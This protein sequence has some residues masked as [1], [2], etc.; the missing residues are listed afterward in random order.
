MPSLFSFSTTT[1]SVP[2]T[3]TPTPNTGI[4][5]P[6]T[7]ASVFANIFQYP[8]TTSTATSQS[9]VMR[10]LTSEASKAAIPLS[11]RKTTLFVSKH[12]EHSGERSSLRSRRSLSDSDL[13]APSS[14]ADHQKHEPLDVQHVDSAT[15]T[16][17]SEQKAG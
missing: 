6:G 2:N 8:P 4:I 1:L 16:L 5:A 12:S 14:A 10:N 3:P 9:A 15:N 13:F 17:E 11:K 7:G